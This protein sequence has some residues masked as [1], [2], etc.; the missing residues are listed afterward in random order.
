MKRLILAAL[1][2][3]CGAATGPAVTI[4]VP[5][6]AGGQCFEL[7]GTIRVSYYNQEQGD[8]LALK[9]AKS[10]L[11]FGLFDTIWGETK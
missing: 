5:T 4:E 6:G 8:P 10:L 7:P 9:I 3:G 1:L 11:D 2:S